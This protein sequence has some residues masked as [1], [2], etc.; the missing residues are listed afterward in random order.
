MLRQDDVILDKKNTNP[1]FLV[2][3]LRMHL[4]PMWIQLHFITI[5]HTEATTAQNIT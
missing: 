5:A 4:F 2:F 3:Q 1:C